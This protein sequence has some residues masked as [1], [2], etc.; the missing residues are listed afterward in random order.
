MCFKIS[1]N[2]N[3]VY[4]DIDIVYC[5]HLLVFFLPNSFMFIRIEKE[6]ILATLH[7]N[8]FKV[9]KKL[10]VIFMLCYRLVIKVVI[11]TH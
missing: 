10:Q 8:K 2:I 5:R 9:T 3:H 1:K 11:I 4:F 7:I 6:C